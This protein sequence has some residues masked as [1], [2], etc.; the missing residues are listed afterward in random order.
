MHMNKCLCSCAVG[1]F[2]DYNGRGKGF[3]WRLVL[4]N[5]ETITVSESERRTCMENWVTCTAYI[6][7]CVI[8]NVISQKRRTGRILELPCMDHVSLFAFIYYPS[9]YYMLK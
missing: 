9:E 5:L 3:E 7:E 2:H 1:T 4:G 6:C 8:R